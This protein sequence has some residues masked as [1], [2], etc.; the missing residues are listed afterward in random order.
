MLSQQS[1]GAVGIESGRP[2]VVGDGV[3]AASELPQK[4][5]PLYVERGVVAV[6]G[7]AGVEGGELFGDFSVCVLCCHCVA[8]IIS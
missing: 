4:L 1:A 6:G 8:E 3:A 7:D 5:P 2:A